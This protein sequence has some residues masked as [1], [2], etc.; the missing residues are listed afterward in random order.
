ML[1]QGGGGYQQK[2][3]GFNEG[4][5]NNLG[6]AIAPGAPATDFEFRVSRRVRYAS[7]NL[8]VLDKNAVTL[9]FESENNSFA[10]RDTAPDSGAFTYRWA[11]DPLGVRYVGTD[12]VEISW[13]GPG[14]LQSRTSLTE[15]DW[16]D[17]ADQTNPHIDYTNFDQTKFYRLS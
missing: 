8:P 12:A 4:N 5:V 2:N 7:D 14:V 6:W 17:E 16:V 3:V 15:G 9:L 10:T 11:L 1:I 13:T